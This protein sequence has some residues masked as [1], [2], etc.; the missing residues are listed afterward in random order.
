MLLREIFASEYPYNVSEAKV[1]FNSPET[2]FKAL[3]S[4]RLSFVFLAEQGD[5]QVFLK[6]VKPGFIR[7][8]I[9]FSVLCTE[10]CRLHSS[11]PTFKTFRGKNGEL[12]QSVPNS[13]DGDSAELS[14]FAGQTMTLTEAAPQVPGALPKNLNKLI[15]FNYIQ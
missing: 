6:I 10:E 5:N 2:H 7:D 11:I 14:F 3:N 8:N 4:G 13:I 12:Y 9:P 1:N 15:M